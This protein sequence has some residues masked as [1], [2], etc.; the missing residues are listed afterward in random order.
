[1][2]HQQWTS[3]VFIFMYDLLSTIFQST[4]IGNNIR[5][6]CP[7]IA[8]QSIMLYWPPL[9]SNN[10]YCVTL[11]LITLH[12]GVVM[13]RHGC[14]CFHIASAKRKKNEKKNAPLSNMAFLSLFYTLKYA[15]FAPRPLPNFVLPLQ[16]K[17]SYAP[18]SQCISY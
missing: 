6:K 10:L 13:R 18:A 17:Y 5:T 2:F 4:G 9:L 14:M 8:I 1:M 15:I 7:Q 12:R 16:V 11:F 3:G